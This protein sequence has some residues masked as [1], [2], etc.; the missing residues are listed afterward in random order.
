MTGLTLNSVACSRARKEYEE[1]LMAC[2]TCLRRAAA[3][4]QRRKS[5]G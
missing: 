2:G 4:A 1:V 3:P 5:N